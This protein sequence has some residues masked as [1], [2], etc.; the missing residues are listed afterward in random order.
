MGTN[1]PSPTGPKT[2]RTEV[3]GKGLSDS[4][5]RSVRTDVGD[6]LGRVEGEA[7]LLFAHLREVLVEIFAARPSI[8]DPDEQR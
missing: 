6:D 2:R 4:F 5:S 8:G 1:K 3:D 7:E